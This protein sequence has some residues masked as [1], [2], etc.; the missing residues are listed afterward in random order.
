MDFTSHPPS[1]RP[2]AAHPREHT[3]QPRA[4]FLDLDTPPHIVTLVLVASVG[5][6]N[7]TSI[8][9]SLPAMTAWF[10]TDYTVM[11]L[12]ISAYLTMTAMLQLIVGPL[13]DRF[14][15]RPV[16]M[17]CITIFLLAT[18]AAALASTIEAF[19]VARLAQATVVGGFVLSR[20]I[21]RD[22]VPVEQA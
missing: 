16:L 17:G 13:S 14:G 21:V 20:A 15:R 22:M 12:A 5:A 10:K 8:L 3:T 19:L 2:D 6:L 18:I 1:D 4:R 11:Q 9:P 7:M